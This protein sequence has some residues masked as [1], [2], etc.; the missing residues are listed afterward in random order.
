MWFSLLRLVWNSRRSFDLCFKVIFEVSGI[1][2][3]RI[4]WCYSC[5][6]KSWNKTSNT[7]RPFYILRIT[8]TI[9]RQSNIHDEFDIQSQYFGHQDHQIGLFWT[10]SF[11]VSLSKHFITK[12]ASLQDSN[13]RLD[14]TIVELRGDLLLNPHF[15]S[16]WHVS[17]VG[18]NAFAL[19]LTYS[20]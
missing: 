9:S 6:P 5:V 15:I 1:W 12:V 7:R 16:V 20:W 11:G 13:I 19:W 14:G 18:E 2:S 17:N 8:F 4:S 10:T 3:G